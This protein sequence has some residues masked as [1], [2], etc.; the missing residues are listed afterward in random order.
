MRDLLVLVHHVHVVHRWQVLVRIDLCV[1]VPCRHLP[2]RYQLPC[3]RLV[4]PQLHGPCIQSVHHVLELL[5]DAV[6][7][8]QPVLRVV[9]HG[10]IRVYLDL[11]HQLLHLL[12]HMLEL[13]HVLHGVPH[14][15]AAVR[16]HLAVL[17][18]VPRW[19]LQLEC[20]DVH[21]LRGPLRQLCRPGIDVHELRHGQLPLPEPVPHLLPHRLLRS[22]RIAGLPALLVQLRGLLRHLIQLHRLL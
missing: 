14:G 8:P 20:G 16:R 17:H 21:E 3:L 11:V 6:P 15:P 19:L 5:V 10:H 7:V 2:Q 13:A 18:H 1:D 9:S 22:Q 12:Q 4:V